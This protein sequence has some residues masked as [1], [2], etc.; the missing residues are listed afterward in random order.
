[1]LMLIDKDGKSMPM[2]LN[3]SHKLLLIGVLNMANSPQLK[4]EHN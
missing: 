4:T 1:M 3:Y 2:K